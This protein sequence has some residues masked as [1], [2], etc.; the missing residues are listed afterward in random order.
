MSK[1]HIRISK[2]APGRIMLL[3][4]TGEFPAFDKLWL[5]CARESSHLG[6]QMWFIIVPKMERR[7]FV[8]TFTIRFWLPCNPK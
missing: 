4:A 7:T 1:F 8:H 5:A 3:S 2:N 6:L